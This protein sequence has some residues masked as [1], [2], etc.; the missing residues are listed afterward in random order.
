V[1]MIIRGFRRLDYN[2][3]Q[4]ACPHDNDVA[5]F[6]LRM[7]RFVEQIRVSGIID[8]SEDVLLGWA[9][10]CLNCR[11]PLI[12]WGQNNQ[13]NVEFIHGLGKME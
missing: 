1:S 4:L 7:Q 13:K 11:E 10:C 12:K 3:K 2:S 6:L 5:R 8:T 9:T